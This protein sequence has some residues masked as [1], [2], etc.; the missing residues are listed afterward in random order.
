MSRMKKVF[1][2]SIG[3]LGFLSILLVVILLL[4]PFLVN[5]E[6]V[7]HKILAHISKEIGGEAQF[8][9]VAI[10]LL[11]RPQVVIQGAKI[12]IPDKIT[13]AMKGLTIV[14]QLIPLLRGNVRI[15]LLQAQAPTLTMELPAQR[16]KKEE[17]LGLSS[18]MIADSLRPLVGLM[19]SKAP[20]LTILVEKGRF[21]LTKSYER[22]FWFQDIQG[23]VHFPPDQL[24]VDLTCKSNLWGH[25]SIAARLNSKDLNGTANIQATDIHPQVLLNY[26]APATALNLESSR[27]NLRIGLEIDRGK[28]LRGKIQASLPSLTFQ[29]GEKKSSLKGITMSG[30]FQTEGDKA[31]ISL[32]ELS[33]QNPR[34]RFGGEFFVDLSAPR[35]RLEF[36]GRE[37]DVSPVRE[38]VMHWVGK[39]EPMQT[40]FDIVR[41]GRVPYVSFKTHGRYPADLSEL[42]NISVQGN[43]VGGR[44]F[45]SESLTGLKDIHFDLRH[46]HGEV[47][48]SRGIL[49]GR[50]L[51]AKW[52]KAGVTRGLLRLGLGGGDTPFHLEAMADVDLAQFPPFLKKI[53]GNQTFSEEMDRLRKLQGRARGR[54]TLGETLNSVQ[55]RIDI[56]EMSLSAHYDRIP[57]Q[58]QVESVQGG[59]DGGK[60]E[61]KNLTGAVGQSSFS[62]ISAQIDLGETPDILVA[63]GKSSIVLEEIYAWLNSIEKLKAPLQEIRSLKGTAALS[64]INLKG[65]LTQPQ[66]WD[67]RLEGEIEKLAVEASIIPGPLSVTAA[68]FEVNPENILLQDSRVNLLDASLKVSAACSGWQQGLSIAE[69]TFQGDL[70][71]KVV[72]WASTRFQLPVNLRIQAPLAISRARLGW[73]LKDGISFTGIWRW[74]GGPD[75]SIDLLHTPEVLTVNRLLIT[76]DGSRADIGL[77]LQAKEL[78]LDFNGELQ[79]RTV[80]RILVKNEF[81]AGSIHGDFRSHLFI[82]APMRSTAQGK[83]AGAGLD[84][85]RVVKLPLV[86]KSFALE[87]DRNIIRVQSAA[88]SWED[89][90][91]TLEG[92]VDFSAE[93]FL[94]DMDVAI[95]GLH[96]EKIKKVLKSEDQKT[97]AAQAGKRKF[98]PLRGRIGFKAT[99]FEYEKFTWRP[100]HLEVTFLPDGV[101]VM[102]TEAK[103][104]GISTAGTVRATSEGIGLNFHPLVENQDFSSSV[105]CLLGKQFLLSGN[106]NF[107]AQIRGQGQ[108]QDLVQSLQGPLELG[109]KDGRIHR[110]SFLLEILAFLNLT[111]L[112]EKDRRD[113]TEGEMGYKEIQARGEL[114][115]GKV[116]IKELLMDAP[117][118]QLFS[119][120]EID[121]VKQKIDFM[122]AVAPLKTVDWV[123]QRI[124]IVD[125]ILEGTLISIPVR[126]QGDLNDPKIVPLDPSLVGS[127]LVGVMKR[128]LKLPFKLVQPLVKDLKKP[129]Q[130]P[131]GAPKKE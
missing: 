72:E 92:S 17:P 121:L 67:Y 109:L 47:F 4:L 124:P 43:L 12:G 126:V 91:V 111:D 27:G 39:T 93:A 56:Q 13:I 49:E 103:V 38:I 55:T 70:G 78:H 89:R 116:L 57:Y 75:V 66:K 97:E 10:V 99:Y 82:D 127:G 115:S 42:R 34:A 65:P 37:M 73:G 6:P 15:S 23:Q 54:L 88:L 105:E 40:I 69:G 7:K 60:I 26:L 9:K 35:F 129:D 46:V 85:A 18:Q 16:P 29:H 83:L 125:Y 48:I 71:A 100:L 1:L 62:G 32:A 120:G 31:T 84:L 20:Q 96:W 44:I 59:Y 30:S 128:T 25:M 108:P 95:D 3:I 74:P 58:V 102:V 80:D 53:I 94:V 86:L 79:K 21:T 81:L 8:H 104:C 64:S 123:V 68:K 101:N 131:S 61:V 22:V 11:P 122:V 117:A 119:H 87:A 98:P 50:N 28:T 51:A 45:L 5:L 106:L 112:L 114:Q 24:Q 2:W 63:A 14:P 110:E 130:K 113:R 19:E 36:S 107:N 77:K 52:E 33:L 41:E 76:D 90:Q 118:M